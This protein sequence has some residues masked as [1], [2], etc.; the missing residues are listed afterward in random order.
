MDF[1]Q[2]MSLQHDHPLSGHSR[3]IEKKDFFIRFSHYKWTT[4]TE[5]TGA[6]N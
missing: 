4:F 5:E 6:Q 2:G 1:N 3:F